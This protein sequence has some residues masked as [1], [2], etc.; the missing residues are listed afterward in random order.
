[1]KRANER[2]EARCKSDA[3]LRYVDLATPLLAD[4]KPREDLFRFDG[5]HLNEHGYR[6]W[7]RVLRPVLCGDLGDC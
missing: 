4:G 6:E 7:T 1:M 5:L 2:I 3:R